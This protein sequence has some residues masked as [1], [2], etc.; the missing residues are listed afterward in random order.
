MIFLNLE[1]KIITTNGRN[2]ISVDPDGKVGTVVNL[3][4]SVIGTREDHGNISKT[5]KL[6]AEGKMSI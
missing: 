6:I 2:L 5:I 3:I 1:R 4:R